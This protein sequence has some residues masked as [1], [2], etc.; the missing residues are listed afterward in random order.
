MKIP[1]RSGKIGT[2]DSVTELAAATAS[3][4]ASTGNR[5]V[6]SASLEF[7]LTELVRERMRAIA[8]HDA[9]GLTGP[10]LLQRA[11]ADVTS[12]LVPALEA[13][14][15]ELEFAPYLKAVKAKLKNTAKEICT[16][17]RELSRSRIDRRIG[18]KAAMHAQSGKSFSVLELGL[19]D[20]IHGLFVEPPEAMEQI[21]VEAFGEQRDWKVEGDWFPYEIHSP[22]GSLFII[23]DDGSVFISTEG[24]SRELLRDLHQKIRWVTEVLYGRTL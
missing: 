12:E 11:A 5:Q 9:M 21:N 7:A 1:R 17:S 3:K 20:S 19:R 16:L 15:L 10:D 6:Y 14:Q 22:D 24:L 2:S 13:N 4:I 8:Q 18:D 23:D